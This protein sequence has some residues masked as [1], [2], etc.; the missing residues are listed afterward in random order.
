[1][2]IKLL[3]ITQIYNLTINLL[4]CKCEVFSLEVSFAKVKV[5]EN[6]RK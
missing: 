6:P 2:S 3:H 5:T 4:L 1:M